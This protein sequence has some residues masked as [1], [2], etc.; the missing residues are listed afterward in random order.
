MKEHEKRMV[1]KVWK[2]KKTNIANKKKC[3]AEIEKYNMNNISPRSSAELNN[4][5][6]VQ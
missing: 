1:R 6:R 3:L 4:D 5:G 2:R